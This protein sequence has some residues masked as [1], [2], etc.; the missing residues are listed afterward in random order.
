M[1]ILFSPYSAPFWVFLGAI[2]TKLIDWHL[3]K[4]K[5]KDDHVTQAITGHVNLNKSLQTSFEIMSG[6][7]ARLRED[8]EKDAADWTA[9]E[10]RYLNRITALEDELAK[11]QQ[12]VLGQVC[13]QCVGDQ[14]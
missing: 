14:L 9:K 8:R 13:P 4:G 12:Q 1:D 7:L 5:A 3:T 10:E 11:I 2:V 6:E